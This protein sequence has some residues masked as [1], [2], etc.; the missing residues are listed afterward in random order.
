LQ[1]RQAAA[2]LSK[3][4][5]SGGRCLALFCGMFFALEIANEFGARLQWDGARSRPPEEKEQ[6]T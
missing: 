5:C 1:T 2:A 4:G 6:Q 3:T